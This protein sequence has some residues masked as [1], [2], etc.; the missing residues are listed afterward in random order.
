M[1]LDLIFKYYFVYIIMMIFFCFFFQAEDG[2]RD[3][4]VTGVQ[5]CALPICAKR[6]ARPTQD[7]AREP[8]R[9][10]RQLDVRSPE[11]DD[12][13]T[14]EPQRDPPERQPVRMDEV[15]VARGPPGG[16]T[17]LAQHQRQQERAGRAAAQIPDHAGAVGDPVVPEGKR[18]DDLDLDPAPA[19]VLDRVGD[20]APRDVLRGAGVRGRED[21][22][23]HAPCSRLDKVGESENRVWTAAAAKPPPPP[24]RHRKRR[25][26]PRPEAV[27]RR[28]AARR[29][30]AA[31]TRRS[32]TRS[33][34]GRRRSP[35][36]S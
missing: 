13:R 30:R 1:I 7:P 28:R 23:L 20:E 29:A 31:R 21:G 19:H 3:P 15:G 33:S 8:G 25:L 32:R 24:D 5:T 9:P 17:K 10:P 2:I 22:H 35:P 4:L 16:A 12:E 6:Q 34:S 14:S 27:A 26:M 18:R 11:L 36:S